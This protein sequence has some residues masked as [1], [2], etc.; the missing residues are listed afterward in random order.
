MFFSLQACSSLALCLL[1]DVAFWGNDIPTGVW[2]CPFLVF[3]LSIILFFFYKQTLCGREHTTVSNA[4]VWACQ[5]TVP[6][7]A[8]SWGN[9]FYEKKNRTRALAG[10]LSWLEHHPVHQKVAGLIPEQGT[11]LDRG[12]DSRS[13]H[14]QEA[15]DRCFSLTSLA[16]S[17]SL[18]PS[19]SFPTTL[20]LPLSKKSVH[21]SLGQN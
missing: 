17:L 8:C 9:K 5:A 6:W 11:F 1:P 10:W 4:L 15:T 20:P 14:I 3:V 13:E 7:I 21:I 19:L 12:F 2:E 18:S 16:L